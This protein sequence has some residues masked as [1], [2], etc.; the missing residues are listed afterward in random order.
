MIYNFAST[1][2]HSSFPCYLVISSFPPVC[3]C[4]R[5]LVHMRSPR[6]YAS[7]FHVLASQPHVYTASNML[8]FPSKD[9][10][11][12]SCTGEN[13]KVGLA[14][15]AGVLFEFSTVSLQDSETS[16]VFAMV[17]LN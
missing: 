3:F 17:A 5:L 4:F 13:V 14:K 16:K 1:H 9:C 8:V 6:I 7:S 2:S 12:T 15:V 11:Y 10:S